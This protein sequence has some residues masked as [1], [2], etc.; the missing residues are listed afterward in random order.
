MAADRDKIL[1]TA[2][3][4]VDKKKY[5]KAIGEYRK[6]IVDDPGD[7]RTLLKIGDLHLKLDQHDEAIATYEQ[8]GDFYYREGFSV[9]AIAVYKQIRGIIKRHAPHLEGRYGHIVPRLAEIYTQLGLTSDALA[10]YDEVATRLRAEGRE[11]DALDIFK[12]V[13]ELD[14]QN[15]IARLRVADSRARLGDIDKAVE[16]FGEAAH[17]MVKLGRIDDALKVLER[18]L[19]Y[20]Q[21]PEWAFM[22]GSLYLERGAPNDGMTA[23]SK[24]QISFKANPKDLRTLS[25][26]ARAFDAI[27]QPKKAVEV[28]KESARI[29]KDTQNSDAFNQLM[30]ILVRRAP[31]DTLVGKLEQFRRNAARDDGVV[32][33][34]GEAEVFVEDESLES[35]D[36]VLEL[37]DDDLLEQSSIER[38]SDHIDDATRRIL[39]E[40]ERQQNAGHLHHAVQLLRDGLRNLGGSYELRQKLG[41]LLLE[42]GDQ[43]G[44]I[45][46]KLILAQEFANEGHIEHALDM[47]DE[48]LLIQP[49]QPDA[50]QMRH[51]LGFPAAHDQ[52]I[53]DLQLNQPLQSYDVESGGVEEALHRSRHASA[54][55]MPAQLDDPFQ[56][57]P[58]PSMNGPVS[59]RGA[60]DENALDQAEALASQGRFDE[61][62]AVLHAQLRM[63]PNH[64]LVLERLNDIDAMAA[65]TS[66]ID[67]HG[68]QSGPRPMHGAAMGSFPGA[69]PSQPIPL[70][71]QEPYYDPYGQQGPYSD[72]Y[73]DYEYR[74]SYYPNSAGHPAHSGY[75]QQPPASQPPASQGYDPYAQPHAPVDYGA[76][77]SGQGVAGTW[78]NEVDS[79]LDQV[80]QGVRNQVAEGDAATHYDLGVAYHEMGLHAD[81][82]SELTLAARDPARECVCLSMIG[83]IQLQLGDYD[84]AL[85]ALERA[86]HSPYKTPDQE[87][88]LGYEIAN[89][90]ELKMMPEQALHFWEWLAQIAPQYND[91]RGSVFDR[92][93]RLR[94]E[95][96][97]QPRPGAP[98]GD[99]YG[100]AFEKKGS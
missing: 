56:S 53:D 46:E 23:L 78:A 29:A 41:D 74:E 93:H 25:M 69:P 81:A 40:A 86:I 63:M 18:L 4:L 17:I 77:Q 59:M 7:V 94:N 13:V 80:R 58:P 52:V 15:P 44:S 55:L 1:Q 88:A 75:S 49:G 26:L 85:D 27:D 61:A 35:L 20:R 34:N 90:Y 87:T 57:Q 96:G 98:Y 60:L 51:N 37:G 21:D 76:P 28:L 72:G 5:D 64:P 9:K 71:H 36:E 83:S 10:A 2:Q 22:A 31:E 50:L 30:D 68:S 6:L 82:I 62:R 66:Q 14:P 45:T 48:V 89:T 54:P 91:P 95:S 84:A 11:R 70:S 99:G 92:L 97:A 79:L 47:L 24:L 100:D 19:E 8:V 73:A 42:M 32:E 39:A 43:P 33:I 3:R 12:K 16:C 38:P 65:R 67:L